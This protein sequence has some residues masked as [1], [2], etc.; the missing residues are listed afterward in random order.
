MSTVRKVT[1]VEYTWFTN[2]ECMCSKVNR[3][4][5]GKKYTESKMNTIKLGQLYLGCNVKDLGG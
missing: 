2:S 3:I 4:K 5:L 1:E